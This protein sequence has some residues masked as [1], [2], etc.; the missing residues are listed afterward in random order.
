MFLLPMFRTVVVVLLLAAGVCC[1]WLGVTYAQTTQQFSVP[2]TTITSE[3]PLEIT[4]RWPLD[5]F[6][7]TLKLYRREFGTFSWGPARQL[8]SLS[9]QFADS[10]IERG[11]AYE[12]RVTKDFEVNTIKDRAFGYAVS[13]LDVPRNALQGTVLLVVDETQAD[14]LDTELGRLED[15]L[16]L[17]GWKVVRH[18]VSRTASVQS[19]RNW[20]VDQYFADPD[21]V[22]SV[23]LFGRIPVPYSGDIAPDAHPDHKGAWP[24]DVYYG[25]IYSDWTDEEVDNNA[26][27]RPEN[28]NVPGDGKFDNDWI[29]DA[30]VLEVGRVDLSNMPA[31]AKSETEL[32]R[33]YLDK[34]HAFRH[35]QLTAPKRALIDDNFGFF[36]GEAFATSGWRN[37]STLVG[38][39][40]IEEKEYFE[41]LSK[42]PYMWAYACGGGWYQGAGG[43]GSTDDF[44]NRGS[45]AIFNIIFGSYFGDWDVENS[46]LRA[47]LATSHG[48][49]NVWAGRPH[50]HFYPLSIGHT[51]GSATRMTQNNTGGYVTNYF[52]NMVHIALMGDPTLR[53]DYGLTQPKFVSVTSVDKA[54]VTVKWAKVAGNTEGYHIYRATMLAGQFEQITQE[55]V[56]DTSFVDVTP[57]IDTN[58]YQV[59]A[60]AKSGAPFASYYNTSLATEGQITGILPKAFVT[61][62]KPLKELMKVNTWRNEIRVSL[63]LPASSPVRLSITDMN[64]REVKLVDEGSLNAGLYNYRFDGDLSDNGAYF[65]RLI[66]G[67]KTETEKVLVLNQTF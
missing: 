33:Q 65:V 24:A 29:P 4:L 6:T 11:V 55:P 7:K 26:A 51:I 60:V 48:L 62:Q 40:N 42:E 27:S 2:I 28:R 19:I 36:G 9:T 16:R 14:P 47:P 25:D 58:V 18:D 23:F 32:L 12:Y 35:G 54:R 41:T 34:N 15:D 37:F 31:F 46:F 39:E 45:K 63:D 61:K 5:T 56:K 49:M 20:I 44:A 67:K 13:G 30:V 57:L 53:M 43:V 64:G 52:Y 3:E 8:D 50:W 66:A 1:G 22:R 21:H 17:D 10:D 59:R 38:Y